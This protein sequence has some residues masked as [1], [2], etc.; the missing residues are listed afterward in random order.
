[1]TEPSN[2]E[3]RAQLARGFHSRAI[4]AGYQPDSHMGSINVPIYASTTFE[5]DGLAQLRGGFEYGRV[6]NPTVRALEKT[7]AALEDAQYARVFSSGMA[8]VD[9][10]LRIIL[11]PGA[12]VILGNDA[13]GGM[14]RLLHNDYGDWGVELSI[15]DTTDVQA[16]RAAIK[17]NTKLIWL[18]TPT[19]PATNITDI[20]AVA[21]VKGNAAVVVDNTFATPYLQNPLA[22]GADHVLHSTTKYL[23]GHSDVLGG[24]VVTNDP[25]MDERLLY[26]QGNTGAVA[27]PFDAY[28]TARGIKTLAV[29]MDRHCQNAQAVAEFLAA[30]AE[31][32]Q[33]LYPGL[34]SHP[35]HEL[36]AKQMRGFG[37]MMSVR[38]HKPEHA[39]QFCLNTR[40]IALAESLGGVESLVEHPQRMTHVSA[41]GSELVPPADLV[42]LSIGIED[43]EDLLE[44]L[45]QALDALD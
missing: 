41:E 14:Y 20:A 23:G 19:N 5:Q 3:R 43:S 36:A 16:V 1:M 25:E 2:H 35:G 7:L 15:V 11:R 18:E 9:T 13:Y 34:A 8:A 12:H 26:F 22:L 40:L 38:F 21:A 44:D 6:A 31:V 37:G 24:A 27:S 29:R 28:L 10:L 4:H 17:D 30:R 32:K 33:V 45:R 42:R 39:T